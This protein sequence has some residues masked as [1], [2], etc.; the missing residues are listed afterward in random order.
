M[1]FFDIGLMVLLLLL[2]LL[3]DWIVSD[4]LLLLDDELLVLDG[5]ANSD[6]VVDVFERLAEELVVVVCVFVVDVV[7]LFEDC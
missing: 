2:L 4:G 7:E 6:E 3:F 5:F 1:I